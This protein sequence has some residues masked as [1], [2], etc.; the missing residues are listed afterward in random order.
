LAK[1]RD[2]YEVL[3]VPRDAT[4]AELKRAFRELARKYH[5]DINPSRTAE[6]KFKEANEAYAILSDPRDRARYDRYG[7]AG[8]SGAGGQGGVP[9]GFQNVKNVIDDLLNDVLRRRQQK[10]QKQRG[11]DLRYTLEVTLEEIVR[12][13]TKSISIPGKDGAPAKEFEV[14]IA[15]GTE[16]GALRTIRG[17][18]QKGDEGGT[19]G[20]LCVIVRIAEHPVFE[21]KGSDLQCEVP[22]TFP[23]AALGAMVEVPTVE[24][25]VKMKI[26]EG[27][28]SGRVFRIRGRG[29]QKPGKKAGERGDQ[30]VRV[31]VE[32]PTRLSE[33]Q[34]QLLEDF[35][36]DAG[37]ELAYPQQRGFLDKLR[38]FLSE[39]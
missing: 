29:I 20:D 26:P 25:M 30:L 1:K 24:G 39:A 36:A 19:T 17:E 4:D 2:Y 16:E 23:Q 5:P 22:V 6:D 14:V 18:G 13:C 10:K 31:V 7:F 38:D 8:V 37:Q 28:Q 15:P 12:G 9:P 34:R 33:R 21:R 3:E 11:R 27:T 35:A 32:T